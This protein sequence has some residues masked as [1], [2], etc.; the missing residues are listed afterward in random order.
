MTTAGTSTTPATTS[1]AGSPFSTIL[2]AHEAAEA[3]LAAAQSDAIPDQAF[4]LLVDYSN[5]VRNE[6]LKAPAGSISDLAA[7]LFLLAD[8]SA[9]YDVSP[10]PGFPYA[11]IAASI[12]EDVAKLFP[13]N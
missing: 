13:A 9:T 7:K 4:E 5:Q 2:K 1:D 6:V 10:A 8:F 12:R 11:E 3:A